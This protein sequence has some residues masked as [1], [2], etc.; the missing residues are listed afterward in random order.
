MTTASL[1][2]SEGWIDIP[3]SCSQEREPLMVLPATSTRTRPVTLAT[4]AR[5][6]RIRTQRW[7][8]ASTA[9]I[10]TRPM[11]TLTSCLRR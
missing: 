2:N 1:A 9:T 3:P 11:A 4:Y 8:V 10:S 5:G 7:S 6:A